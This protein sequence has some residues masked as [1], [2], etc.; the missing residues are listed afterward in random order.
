[1]LRY[2]VATSRYG[3]A[4][5]RFN[6]SQ[7]GRAYTCTTLH[8]AQIT[9]QWTLNIV[10]GSAAELLGHTL[11]PVIP[12]RNALRAVHKIVWK[13][14]VPMAVCQEVHALHSGPHV[15][16][17]ASSSSQQDLVCC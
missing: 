17:H 9:D 4:L 11:Q 8:M 13:L 10:M 15:M 1:M 3:L 7:I 6:S 2:A 16:S 5:L 12:G 14:L